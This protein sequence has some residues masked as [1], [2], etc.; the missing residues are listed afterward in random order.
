MG[1]LL[2]LIVLAVGTAAAAPANERTW[3]LTSYLQGTPSEIGRKLNGELERLVVRRRELLA[4]AEAAKLRLEATRKGA[5]ERYGKD[6]RAVELAVALRDAE[7][8]R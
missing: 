1:R 7:Q 2:V 6:K 5:A 4:D 8:V 3:N